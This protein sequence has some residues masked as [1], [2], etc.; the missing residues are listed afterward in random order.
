[1]PPSPSDCA[2][3]L[4][5]RYHQLLWPESCPVSSHESGAERQGAIRNRI[6]AESGPRE[7]ST[8]APDAV[9]PEGIGCYCADQ[10]AVAFP[11]GPTPPKGPLARTS[12]RA[13]ET[14]RRGVSEPGKARQPLQLRRR[15][16]RVTSLQKECNLRGKRSDPYRG[17]NVQPKAGAVPVA[18]VPTRENTNCRRVRTTSG[19]LLPAGSDRTGR[20]D[21]TRQIP[22]GNGRNGPAMR[23]R[24]PHA[25]ESGV[26]KHTARESEAPNS[27]SLGKS[28]WRTPTPKFGPGTARSRG[29]IVFRIHELASRKGRNGREVPIKLP[30]DRRQIP[31]RRL[32]R[33][34]RTA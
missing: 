29:L 25:A 12:G 10:N 6:R 16:K 9:T 33:A 19:E 21:L 32:R 24:H 23:P 4:T 27:V 28:A 2:S 1:M 26:G 13:R 18:R 22:T 7:V 5:G 15:E 3:N 14:E 34:I 17:A 30:T 11:G 8:R 20:R 31:E